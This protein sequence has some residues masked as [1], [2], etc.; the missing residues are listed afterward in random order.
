VHLEILLEERSA[1]ETLNVLLP[2]LLDPGTSWELHAFEGKRDLLAKVTGRLRGYAKWIR[3][4]NTKIV[5]L[6]DEDRQDCHKLKSALEMAAGTAGLETKTSAAGGPFFVL[7]RLAVEE[8]EAWFFGD[9]QALRAAYPRI[10]QHID[11]KA[12]CRHPDSITGGTWNVS[13]KFSKALDIIERD[14]PN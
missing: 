1:E 12:F 11:Q 9:S 2:R 10:P 14:S 8:L 7:N 4:A 13:R 3:D 5:V 6:V